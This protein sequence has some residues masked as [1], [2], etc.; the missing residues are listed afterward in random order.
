MKLT[1]KVF[2]LILL[3]YVHTAPFVLKRSSVPGSTECNKDQHI[4]TETSVIPIDELKDTNYG[5]GTP[6]LETKVTPEESPSGYDKV[7]CQSQEQTPET[8]YRKYPIPKSTPAKNETIPSGK[9]LNDT[10]SYPRL[11]Q[12]YTQNSITTPVNDTLVVGEACNDNNTSAYPR[13]FQNST[14]NSTTT[15]LYEPLAV[16]KT[17]ND[18]NTSPYVEVLSE[19]VAPIPEQNCTAPETI[20]SPFITEET[21]FFD[22]D[23][24]SSFPLYET[25]DNY[26]EEFTEHPT[27]ESPP[28]KGTPTEACEESPLLNKDNKDPEEV[29]LPATEQFTDESPCEDDQS[30]STEN[31]KDTMKH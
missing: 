4:P 21:G 11:F 20:D 31:I 28:L 18:T 27:K 6:I 29:Y 19:K 30:L 26:P 22:D 7:D 17:C 16:V 12:D 13:L 24:L 3:G 2:A 25:N 5:T 14:Q 1:Y 9:P 8:S 23:S 10:K 15:P